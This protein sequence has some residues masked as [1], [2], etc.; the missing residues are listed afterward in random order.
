MRPADHKLAGWIDV[1]SER[2]VDQVTRQHRLDD[3]LPDPI[4]DLGMADV[5]VVLRRDDHGVDSHRREALVLDRHLALRIRPKPLD[6]TVFP[7]VRDPINDPVRK[8]NRQ[9]HQF[10]SVIACE[11][12]HH[13]LVAGSD[14]LPSCTVFIDALS[15]VGRLLAQCNHHR[16]RRRIKPHVTGCVTDLAHDLAHDRGVVDLR[17]GRDLAREADQPGCQQRLTGHTRV[18]IL[19]QYGIEHAIGNLVR[20]L[21][22]MAHGHRFAGE[23]IAIVI[24]HGRKSPSGRAS[25]LENGCSGRR[26]PPR[27]V[28]CTYRREGIMVLESNKPAHR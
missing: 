4:H 16:A 11:A 1:V 20:H 18:R 13:P 10:R 8:R 23:K 22:G 14:V 19:R 21:V 2:R 9:R 27:C 15:D 7:Q 25:L 24:R 26:K 6:G 17:F 5:R 12:E 3:F 28:S